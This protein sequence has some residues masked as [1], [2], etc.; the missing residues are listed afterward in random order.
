MVA[1]SVRARSGYKRV[2]PRQ[3]TS[4]EATFRVDRELHVCAYWLRLEG[5][6]GPAAS[7]FWRDTEIMRIDMLQANPHLHYRF[8]GS[9]GHVGASRAQV[10]PAPAAVLVD[11]LEHELAANMAFALHIDPRPAVNRHQLESETVGRVA[12]DASRHLRAQVD[13]RAHL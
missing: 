2:E 11:R 3:D 6:E 4:A 12:A 7:V 5:D 1:S 8:Y 9:R 13:T 10:Q